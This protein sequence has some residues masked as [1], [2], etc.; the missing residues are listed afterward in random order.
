[1][2]LAERLYQRTMTQSRTIVNA[3]LRLPVPESLSKVD[4]LG[5]FRWHPAR[6]LA[7]SNAGWE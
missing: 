2:Y 6:P 7:I 3:G 1:M 5:L 4:M